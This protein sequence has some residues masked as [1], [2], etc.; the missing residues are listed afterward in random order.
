M[1]PYSNA[2]EI[3][4]A[5]STILQS[6]AKNKP[7]SDQAK[8]PGNEC[9]LVFWEFRLGILTSLLWLLWKNRTC[10]SW[11]FT[12][13][14]QRVEGGGQVSKWVPLVSSFLSSVVAGSKNFPI[15]LHQKPTEVNRG[16]A[17]ELDMEEHMGPFI[18]DNW[19]LRLETWDQRK[20]RKRRPVV[21][22]FDELL[23]GSHRSI[24]SR[25]AIFYTTLK[26]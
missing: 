25:L 6:T 8:H 26:F 21:S 22:Q 7:F 3:C 5:L 18:K 9:Y 11:L 13:G 16:Q 2:T 1:L 20:R 14:K 23:N 12:H 15:I 10:N 24:V 17:A 4:M 19:W